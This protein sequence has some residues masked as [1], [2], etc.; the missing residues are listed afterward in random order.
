MFHPPVKILTHQNLLQIVEPRLPPPVLLSDKRT[1][2]N[3]S[4]GETRVCFAFFAPALSPY[5]IEITLISG[6]PRIKTFNCDFK[7]KIGSRSISSFVL[8]IR[9]QTYSTILRETCDQ[10]VNISL[11]FSVG[12]H[13]DFLKILNNIIHHSC[14]I[15]FLF[16]S[17]PH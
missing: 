9:L 14:L 10:N 12:C 7:I 1:S 17:F 3:A 13:L 8:E 5:F 4:F 15:I 16:S 6:G 11:M 2:V